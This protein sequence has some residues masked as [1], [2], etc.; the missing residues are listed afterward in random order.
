MTKSDL[1]KAMAKDFG[2]QQKAKL[3]LDSMLEIITDG[4]ANHETV[5]LTGF[6]TLKVV[7]RKAR[8]G[9]NPRTGETVAIPSRRAVKFTP[10]E[11][12]KTAL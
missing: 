7:E 8:R 11:R 4:L 5:R 2:S 10:G 9:R 3:V 12:L 6:G 1:V